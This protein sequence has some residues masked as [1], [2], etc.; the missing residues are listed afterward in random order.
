MSTYTPPDTT[1]TAETAELSVAAAL[2]QLIFGATATKIVT[3][4]VELGLPEHLAAGPRP[5]GDLAADAEVDPEALTRLLRGLAGLG[6]VRQLDPDRFGLTGLGERLRPGSPDAVHAIFAMLWGSEGWSAWG[7]LVECVRTGLPAWD[8]VHGQTWVE[9]YDAHPAAS[10]TFNRAMSQHTRGTAAALVEA[11]QVSRFHTVV[12]VGGGDG[13][14]LASMLAREPD[15][16]GVVFDLPAGLTDAG[17]T[18]EAMGVA[19]RFRVVPGDFFAEVPEQAD[20]YVLKQV[21]HDWSDDDAVRILRRCRAAMR[22]DSRL[23]VLERVLPDLAGPEHAPAL[24]LDIHMLTVTGGRER[25]LA[26]FGDLLDES[27]FTLT[28]LTG[29]LP[30]F[31]YH[32]LEAAP[33]T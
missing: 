18:A 22:R 16:R 9:Y 17:L 8:A 3:A 30:P 32:V 23:L 14:L 6:V 19:D 26:E 1:E 25:T 31:D 33:R 11:C 2:H 27:G 13:M 10:R 4:A 24:L 7:G 5:V 15:L 20:A 28:G 21:L 29:P 12:D